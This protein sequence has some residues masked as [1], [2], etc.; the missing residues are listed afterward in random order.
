VRHSSGAAAIFDDKVRRFADEDIRACI[1]PYIE[2]IIDAILGG[3]DVA[4]KSRE[5]PFE[6]SASHLAAEADLAATTELIRQFLQ[7][8]GSGRNSATVASAGATTS[9]SYTGQ[10]WSPGA[11]EPVCHAPGL[12]VP[13]FGDVIPCA[14][15]H[16]S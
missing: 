9:V 11:W 10:G 8:S 4:W 1:K 3:D 5:A 16:G 6:L 12:G 14:F 2:R 7:L 13:P 15:L